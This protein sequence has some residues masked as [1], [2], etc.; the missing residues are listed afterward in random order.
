LS[1]PPIY[2][3]FKQTHDPEIYDDT[4]FY[5]QLLKDIMDSSIDSSDPLEMT[6]A[7]MKTRDGVTKV[8]KNVDRRASKNRRLRYT[9]HEKL[10]NFMAPVMVDGSD[11][12]LP[13]G[14][15]TALFR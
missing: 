8:K 1:I 12:A 5:S 15:S 3:C 9:V 11:G 6:R 14:L 13:E 4:E 7:W 10:V 2:F